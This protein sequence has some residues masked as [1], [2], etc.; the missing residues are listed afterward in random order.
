MLVGNKK[1]IRMDGIAKVHLHEKNIEPTKM[2]DGLEM[3]HK[4][5]A[6]AYL[7]CSAKM[8]DRVREVFDVTFEAIFPGRQITCCAVEDDAYYTYDSDDIYPE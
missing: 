4:I 2:K 7:E 5:G 3:A 8:N 6:Y 1:D